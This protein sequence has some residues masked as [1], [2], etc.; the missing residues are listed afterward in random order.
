MASFLLF[1]AVFT[2]YILGAKELFW[3]AKLLSMSS[4]NSQK[5]F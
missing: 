1:P 3:V 2:T 4:K 5:I